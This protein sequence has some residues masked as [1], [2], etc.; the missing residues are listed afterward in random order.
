MVRRGALLGLVLASCASPTASRVVEPTENP[1]AL[2]KPSIEK[3][4][5]AAPPPACESDGLRVF[6]PDGARLIVAH[7]AGDILVYDTSSW[8]LVARLRTTPVARMFFVQKY[9][10]YV[11]EVDAKKSVFAVTML[12]ESLRPVVRVEN[13][14]TGTQG[15]VLGISP[16][17]KLLAVP[18]VATAR[19]AEGEQALVTRVELWDVAKKQVVFTYVVGEGE[20]VQSISV[21]NAGDVLLGSDQLQLFRKFSDTPVDRWPYRADPAP[22]F[23]PNGEFVTFRWESV[24]QAY[25]IKDKKLRKLKD[26]ACDGQGAV[27]SP[28]GKTLATGGFSFHVCLFDPVSGRLRQTLP[29]PRVSTHT[30]EDEG[31]REPVFF[32]ND[33]RALVTKG[34]FELLVFDVKAGQK[35]DLAKLNPL[36]A[37]LSS[38]N[39]NDTRIQTRPR[40]GALLVFHLGWFQAHVLGGR[41]IGDVLSD[42]PLKQLAVSQDG[43]RFVRFDER[44]TLMETKVR[45]SAVPVEGTEDD[46]DAYGDA[47]VFD[48]AGKYLI[49]GTGPLRVWSAETGKRVGPKRDERCPQR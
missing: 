41:L 18:I 14:V 37:G 34:L 33:G 32:S 16:D 24:L 40:D 43:E 17:A 5:P 49:S 3:T 47:F 42:E 8:T 36:H 20:A 39:Q 9:F 35:Y 2:P 13:A 19:N 30:V 10:V 11:E 21:T 6:S 23:S 31:M 38:W 29:N 44:L 28:D 12:D 1:V 46:K 15:E 45:G 48:L 22:D 7:E 27:W 26:N 4:P 25:G